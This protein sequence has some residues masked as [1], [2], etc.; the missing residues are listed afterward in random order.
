MSIET[1][2]AIIVAGIALAILCMAL[3]ALLYSRTAWIDKRLKES[4]R[5]AMNNEEALQ[6]AVSHLNRN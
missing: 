4:G 5:K 1:I 3:G 2:A 6:W